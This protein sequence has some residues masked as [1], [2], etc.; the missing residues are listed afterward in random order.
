MVT[1]K[2][3]TDEV[4]ALDVKIAK[5]GDILVG[6]GIILDVLTTDLVKV[7]VAES[8]LL[9]ASAK[10]VEIGGG[11][12]ID[13]YPNTFVKDGK[14]RI[15][16]SAKEEVAAVQAGFKVA[17]YPETMVKANAPDKVVHSDSEKLAAEG[18]GYKL[19]LG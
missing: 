14:Y 5:L 9:V 18:L 10:N 12:D 16:N 8:S 2:Q 13:S 6:G 11:E 1:Q 19:P 3:V 7:I 4:I 15:V 17:G